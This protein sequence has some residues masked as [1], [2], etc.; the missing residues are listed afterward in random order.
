MSCSSTSPCN[1]VIT[2][3]IKKTV[4][5]EVTNTLTSQ[6]DDRSGTDLSTQALYYT[7]IERLPVMVVMLLV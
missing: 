3:G 6:I 2:V 4:L 1:F 7:A 5:G